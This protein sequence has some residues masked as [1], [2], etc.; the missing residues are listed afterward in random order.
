MPSPRLAVG[1]GLK[2]RWETPR[3]SCCL[4]KCLLMFLFRELFCPRFLPALGLWVFPC[5]CGVLLCLRVLLRCCMIQLRNSRPKNGGGVSRVV[6]PVCKPDGC[7]VF[8]PVQFLWRPSFI[9]VTGFVLFPAL[10][11]PVHAFL[12][13]LPSLP[14][15]PG[16]LAGWARRN[17]VFIKAADT[18]RKS[19]V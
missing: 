16:C 7:C 13:P 2:P 4:C 12:H 5:C 10:L 14:S 9:S 3:W 15:S 6:S 17:W 19:V 11:T 18:D 1:F 8:Q